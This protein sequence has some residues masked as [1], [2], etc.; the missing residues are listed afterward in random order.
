MKIGF[1]GTGVMG[2]AMIQNLVKAEHQVTAY[3]RTIEKA[4]PLKKYGVI[5]ADSIEKCVQDAEIVITI[6]GYPQDVA[7]VYQEIFKYAMPHTICLDMTTSS[8][9]L[10][11]DLYQQ[12]QKLNIAVL[13]AP[14]SGGDTGAKQG[15][16]SIMVGGDFKTF[17]QVLPILKAMGKNITYIGSAGSGQ[18][19]KMANQIAIA[20]T[21]AGVCEALKYADKMQLDKNLVL[22]AIK[23][24]A[25][26]S[27]QMSNTAY[28]ILENDYQPGFYIK[29]FIKDMKI[30]QNEANQANI[31]L[32]ILNEVLNI[33]QQ[34]SDEGYS[35]A[36]TSALYK[37]YE[38]M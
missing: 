4:I 37:Y 31:H 27:W 2:A 33:Y 16:L 21:L 29:H 10:A 35:E 3:N 18:N 11:K 1:I 26:G 34:L 22:N 19:T 28:R 38:K 9:S 8:P 25:A 17:Q 15:S 5:V 36:A 6:V 12:G 20:G 7:A 23:N 30:A 24:G 13:D 14:V 32:D